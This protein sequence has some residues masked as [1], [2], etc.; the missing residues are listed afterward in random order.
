LINEHFSGGEMPRRDFVV[1]G[2]DMCA[3]FP[4]LGQMEAEYWGVPEHHSD[5]TAYYDDHDPERDEARADY[6]TAQ[7]LETIDWMEKALG[8]KFDDEAYIESI[9]RKLA[10]GGAARRRY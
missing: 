9:K 8:T 3:M 10:Y 7:T 6:L 4:K 5:T 2:N 1:Q